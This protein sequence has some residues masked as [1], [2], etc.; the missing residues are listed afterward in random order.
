MTIDSSGNMGIGTAPGTARLKVT[1]DVNDYAMDFRNTG[2]ST[3]DNGLYLSCTNTHTDTMAFYAQGLS[4]KGDGKVGIGNTAPTR[5]FT[6]GGT[7]ANTYMSIDTDSRAWTFGVGVVSHGDDV[8]GIRD[9]TAG[10][11]RMTINTSGN[12]G[13]GT[14]PSTRILE[15]GSSFGMVRT[16][17]GAG[18]FQM[19]ITHAGSSNYGSIYMQATASTGGF[20][21]TCGGNERMKIDSNGSV[22]APNL[23]QTGSTSNRYPLYWVHTGNVGALEPYTGSLREMKTNISDMTSVDWIYDLKLRSFNWRDFVDNEDGTRN[24]LETFENDP[25]IDYG[26][27]ADEVESIGGSQYIVDK[28]SEGNLKGVLYHNLTPILLKAIQ[29]LS[30][31]VTALENA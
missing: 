21:F 5:Q 6:V 31:K 8:F 17:T 20:H 23:N 29:E 11:Y 7:E 18:E 10:S 24:Y 28:D 3:G 25:K 2:A 1:S 27:I 19:Y 26:L 14:A 22:Y 12:V 16:G 4:V 30:A 9:D 15:T 13:I